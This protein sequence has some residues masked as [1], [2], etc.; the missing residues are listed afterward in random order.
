MAA[1]A[2][3]A[4]NVKASALATYIFKNAGVAI[5]AGDDIYVDANGLVQLGNNSAVGTIATA[6]AGNTAAVGQPVQVVTA[7][8]SFQHG[9][10]GVVAGNTIWQH[11]AAG[12]STVTDADN[13]PGSFT[14]I[15]GHAIS[16]TMMK[17]NPLSAG[18][19]HA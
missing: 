17:L 14:N 7:D 8:P 10:T 4:A 9:L 16:A 2:K 3:T 11:T 13:T 1:L 6:K 12:S 5:N 18:V 19:A 15:L